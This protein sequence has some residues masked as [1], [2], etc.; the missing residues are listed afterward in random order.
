MVL[1]G[2]TEH[3]LRQK[4]QGRSTSEL[5]MEIKISEYAFAELGTHSWYPNGDVEQA[6]GYTCW[7]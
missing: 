1:N 7:D 5:D 3:L 6:T 4:Y 2:G